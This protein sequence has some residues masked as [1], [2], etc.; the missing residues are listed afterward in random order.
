MVAF[1]WG[2]LT[3]FFFLG[4]VGAGL[5]TFQID[6]FAVLNG[7]FSSAAVLITFGVLIGKVNGE[8]MLVLTIL[9]VILQS[10]NNYVVTVVIGTADFG[11]SIV[12]HAFGA[13]FGMAA[14][15]FLR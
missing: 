12:I 11:G 3:N 13:Y 5:R 7:L 8:I 10:V 15:I 6:M 2:I 4:Y 1:E 14:T 9:E